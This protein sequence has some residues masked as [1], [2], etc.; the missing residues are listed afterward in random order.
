MKFIMT[1]EM[2]PENRTRAVE[3]F[4][5]GGALPPEGATMLGR[6]HA[7]AGLHGF[8]LLES[9]DATAIY[10][11]AAQWHDLLDFGITPVVDDAEAGA[12]LQSMQ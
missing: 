3:R 4:L 9:E 12:V 11:W 10:R 7:A 1:Y 6:W 2:T 8:I 5:E